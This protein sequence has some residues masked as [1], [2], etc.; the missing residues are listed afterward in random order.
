MPILGPPSAM[1]PGCDAQLARK[2][3]SGARGSTTRHCFTAPTRRVW[4]PPA[5]GAP[6]REPVQYPTHALSRLIWHLIPPSMV[7]I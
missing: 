6:S 4:L 2:G 3:T 7:P 1:M 5:R